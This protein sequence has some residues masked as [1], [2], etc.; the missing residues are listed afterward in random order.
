MCYKLYP[1]I[2]LLRLF[3]ESERSELSLCRSSLAVTP[4]YVT[5]KVTKP[6]ISPYVQYAAQIQIT[7]EEKNVGDISNISNLYCLRYEYG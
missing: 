7:S 2:K 1:L 3:L 4:F 6:V 5:E